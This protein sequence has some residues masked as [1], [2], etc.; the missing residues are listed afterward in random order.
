MLHG[1]RCKLM[2]LASYIPAIFGKPGCHAL[3]KF[4]DTPVAVAIQ[5]RREDPVPAAREVGRLRKERIFSAVQADLL[6]GP[7]DVVKVCLDGL[8]ASL[9][10]GLVHP[11]R[12]YSQ[13]Q[14]WDVGRRPR[15]VDERYPHHGS[16]SDGDPAP[17]RASLKCPPPREAGT[18]VPT[19]T[20]VPATRPHLARCE[21]PSRPGP[22]NGVV[23]GC[24]LA[25]GTGGGLR[26]RVPGA[27][28]HL[29][30]RLLVPRPRS[31]HVGQ[32]R[33]RPSGRRPTWLLFFYPMSPRR[34]LTTAWCYWI[35][36]TAATGSSTAPARRR[37]DCF[38]MVIPQKP[39]RPGWHASSPRHP[40]EPMPTFVPCWTLCSTHTL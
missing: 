16:L 34:K 27:V 30:L 18:A 17:W 6:A 4:G 35:S 11:G 20:R 15:H 1:V 5:R 36:G 33:D 26:T 12:E 28:G 3:L 22:R 10:E 21:G 19:V 38:S 39:R 37:C 8:H 7:I 2:Q 29:G 13:R 23:A 14:R 9:G 25:S 24:P 31:R 32:I 40:N